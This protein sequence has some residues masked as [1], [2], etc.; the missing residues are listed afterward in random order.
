MSVNWLQNGQKI[1]EKVGNREE[2]NG[3]M[4]TRA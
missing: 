4:L 2:L 3:R 1:L